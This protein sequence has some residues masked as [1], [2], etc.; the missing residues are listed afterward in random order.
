ME[1]EAESLQNLTKTIQTQGLESVQD[2]KELII[3]ENAAQKS[4]GNNNDAFFSLPSYD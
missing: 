2:L 3:N 1:K 4:K